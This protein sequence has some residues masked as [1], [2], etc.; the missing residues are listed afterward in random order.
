MYRSIAFF[1]IGLIIGG[2]ITN[3]S[4]GR[5]LDR[6][7]WENEK[8]KISLYE[9]NQ[10]LEKM[11]SQ[12]ESHRFAVVQDVKIEL[13]IDG[14]PF[15]ELAVRQAISEITQKLIGEEIG[16]LSPLLVYDLL[17]NRIIHLNDEEEEKYR[18]DV[19]SVIISTEVIYFIRAIS[20]TDDTSPGD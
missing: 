14:S 7:Y 18:L 5:Q 16:S 2:I 13:E 4:A 12:W 6:L 11:R 9:S 8:L 3:I 19:Q 15:D 10:R 17:H 1:L 20:L